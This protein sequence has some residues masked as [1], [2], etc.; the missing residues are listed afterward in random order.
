MR[1]WCRCSTGSSTSRCCG[2]DTRRPP[3]WPRP[4]TW[5]RPGSRRRRCV[6]TALSP[7][8][9]STAVEDLRNRVERLA[10]ALQ[11][12]GLDVRVGDDEGAILWGKLNFLAPLT[13]LTTHEDAAA[14]VVRERRRKELAAVIAE[15]AGVARAEGAPAD[16]HGVLQ[17]FDRVPARM[18]S[19]MQR[20]A[21]AGRPT[22]LDAIGGAVV[23][24]AA[25][26]GIPVPV[27]ARLV[28]QLR[29]RGPASS[30]ETR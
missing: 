23:R 22:E 18:Q 13:L 9:S 14:G 12:A 1:W 30:Q 29:A 27:T 3:W 8:S 24:R 6:T 25:R 11:Q 20:A 7:R 4:S 10:Q 28:D 26:H 2:T 19:S 5:S 16:E 21:A 17:F 15:V